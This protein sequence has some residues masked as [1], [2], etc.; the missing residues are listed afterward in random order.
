M[1]GNFCEKK[2]NRVNK[3]KFSAQRQKPN[4]VL[5]I[6]HSEVSDVV[7]GFEAQ[8]D[9]LGQEHQTEIDEVDLSI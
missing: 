1:K 9:E 5:Q 3:L 4:L 6:I 7:E 2:F 8:L